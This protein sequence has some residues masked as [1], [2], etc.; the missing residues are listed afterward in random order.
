MHIA[1]SYTCGFWWWW[2]GEGL[3][4]FILFT[5]VDDDDA[6]L[7]AAAVVEAL[8]NLLRLRLRRT[9]KNFPVSQAAPGLTAQV[10]TGWKKML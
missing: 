3:L 10:G 2:S 1:A 9:P 8:S 5:A 4:F 6:Q 7:A